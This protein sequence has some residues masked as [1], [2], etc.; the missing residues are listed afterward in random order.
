MTKYTVRLL[1]STELRDA[2]GGELQRLPRQPKRLGL[3]AYLAIARPRGFHRRDKLVAL[4]WPET[5]HEHAR[6]AL[7]QA[8]HVLRSELGEEAIRGR[9]DSDV[10]IDEAALS[11]DV[12]EFESAVEDGE[13]DKALELYRGDLLEGLFVRE[14]LEFERWLEDERTRL[15]EK[16]AGA[17]WGLAHEHIRAD[18]LVDAER[19]AQRALLLVLT[20]ESEVRRF[21]QALADAGDR[22]AAVRFYDKFAQRLRSEYEI[23]PDPLTVAVAEQLTKAPHR[24]RTDATSGEA[25][26]PAPAGLVTQR[27]GRT[28]IDTR[29]IKIAAMQSRKVW[30]GVAAAAV[31]IMALGTALLL[32][33]WRGGAFDPS[34]VLVV[35][36]TDNSGRE[37]AAVLGSMVQDYIIQ[38]LTDAGFGEVVDPVTALAASQ[39]VAAAAVAPGAEEV[40]AL[41]DE[42]RAGTVVSGSYYATG[43]S[44]KMQ[45]RI[46][47]VSEGKV[48]GTV[49][50]IA[51]SIAA[52]SELVGRLADA[53]VAALAAL[54]DEDLGAWEPRVQPATVGAYEAYSEGIEAYLRD[55]MLDAARHF[56]RAVTADPM[57]SRARLWAAQSYLVFEWLPRESSNLAKVD[58]LTAPLIESRAQLSRYDRCHLDLVMAIRPRRST[59]ALYEAARC[60][61]QAAP[62]SDNAKKE[63]AVTALMVNRPGEA[64]ELLRQ[65][66]PDRGLTK[67][68]WEYW[69][70][71]GFAYHMLG[72]YEREL[73]AAQKWRQ[74]FPQDGSPNR[75]PQGWLDSEAR[76][77][78]ALGRLD[79]VA[80]AAQEMRSVAENL[81][82]SLGVLGLDLRAHGHRDA[83]QELLDESVRWC[84]SR[85]DETE[86][87]RARLAKWLY[88]A[89]RW[90]DAGRLYQDLAGEYPENTEY[91]AALGR[92]AARRGDREV[93]LRISEELG[94]LPHTLHPARIAAVLGDSEEA[95]TLLQQQSDVMGWGTWLFLHRDIDFESLHDYPPFQEF[96]KPKG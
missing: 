59:P 3:L 44:I 90:D 84:R 18:R 51:G 96:M 91:L 85:L 5:G 34:R 57:F 9:G 61:A 65:L 6:H 87:T 86:G 43:D 68:W 24:R 40:L 58:S 92:L 93:A 52:P 80:A 72:E 53:V 25:A 22:A 39:N 42:A 66:D 1:G 19:T 55:S 64:V 23:E 74:G 60:M 7:S 63:A 32:S 82:N 54:F 13:Y 11:C 69:P 48:M 29:P 56:G 14:A 77:L 35:E 49:G 12:V 2:A 94:S 45:T 46:I 20:D 28:Q 95:M 50:P 31:A 70:L 41:A 78:A 88:Q 67:Q 21:I 89:E 81:G 4:F 8:L 71:L 30:V 17:A 37:D 16:A 38:I 27:G 15:R 79:D 76:A 33:S 73:E 47:D 26:V 10:A 75:P 62:G 83:A 36:F